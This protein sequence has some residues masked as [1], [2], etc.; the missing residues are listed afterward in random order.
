MCLRTFGRKQDD[1]CARCTYF[2][3]KYRFRLDNVGVVC[4]TRGRNNCRSYLSAL[5][6]FFFGVQRLKKIIKADKHKEGR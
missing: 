4:Y 5:I 2:T 3:K 1:F 6:I